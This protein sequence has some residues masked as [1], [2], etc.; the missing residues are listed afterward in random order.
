MLGSTL[1]LLP[2]SINSSLLR[3]LLLGILSQEMEQVQGPWCHTEHSVSSGNTLLHSPL[4]SSQ[5]PL[6][7][8]KPLGYWFLTQSQEINLTPTYKLKARSH[9]A[10]VPSAFCLHL[11]MN[12]HH[13]PSYSYTHIQLWG[14]GDHLPSQ[15]N[16]RSPQ[17][18][19]P[20]HSLFS[21]SLLTLAPERVQYFLPQLHCFFFTN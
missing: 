14:R 5:Q 21:K 9:Q 4:W 19:Q 11:W 18:P 16:L 7:A 20:P 15:G 6:F 13:T 12:Q 8:T 2:P 1:K 10:R 17:S 3:L